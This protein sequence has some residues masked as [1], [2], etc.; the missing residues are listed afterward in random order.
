MP[1]EETA[2]RAAWT[3]IDWGR[4]GENEYTRRLSR[5]LLK[6]TRYANEQY[7]DWPDRENCGH[8]FGGSYWYGI[9]SAYTAAVFAAVGTMPEYDEAVTGMPQQEVRSK[10]IRAIRYLSFTHDTGPEECVRVEGPN[11]HCSRKKW[12]GRG[13]PFFRASQTGTVVHAMAC[14]AWLLH[15]ELDEETKRLMESVLEYY[16]DRYSAMKPGTGVYFD[17]QCEENGWT[18][19]GIGAAA[20]LLPNHP[21]GGEWRQAA[22]RWA[23]N[24]VTTPGDNVKRTGGVSTVT[25]HPDYTTE[26]HAFVH[27]SY[28][29]AGISLRGLYALLE[30]MAGS[31]VPEQ[32]TVGNV[33]MYERTI[34]LWSYT[35]GIPVPIQGQDWWYNLHHASMMCHAFIHVLHGNPDA[36]AL[37][38]SAL[39]FVEKLQIS[40]TR[41]CLLE[42][43]G[44]ACI[45]TEGHQTAKEMEFGCAHSVLI[46]Y[47][48][49]RFGGAGTE[50]SGERDLS[51]AVN[52]VHY[53]PYGSS[54][55]HRTDV[56]FTAFS[57]RNHVMAITLPRNGVWSV[58]PA[59]SS[60][61][62]EVEFDGEQ[63]DV[64][65]NETTPVECDEQHL[66][67]FSDGFGAV[68]ELQRGKGGKLLQRIGF[69]SLPDGRSFYA[70]RIRIQRPCTIKR[71]S[72]GLIGIRN[73]RYSALPGYA[74]G[75]KTVTV[76]GSTKQFEGYYGQDPDIVE[77][78][79]PVPYI[80]VN[81]EIG[82]VVI[83]SDNVTYWNRHQYAKWKG[84][85]DVLTLNARSGLLFGG[86]AELP[87][88]AVLALPNASVELTRESANATR[89]LSARMDDCIVAETEGYLILVNFGG[90]RTEYQV[91]AVRAGRT[92]QL[93]DGT[94]HVNGGQ[95][96][97]TGTVEASYAGYAASR[98]RLELP[99][100]LPDLFHLTVTV[101]GARVYVT[102]EARSV[103]NCTLT[104]TDTG[105]S[106]LRREVSIEGLCT[107]VFT[108]DR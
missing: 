46:A 9:E 50:P 49:H 71:L 66:H 8:F 77:S 28:M 21:R 72:T 83:G 94:Q 96:V 7:A 4:A 20:A 64:A 40:N 52:G 39:E 13:D 75:S 27:P 23:R 100:S 102:N 65:Y 1:N 61:I 82:Y 108:F 2:S 19:S 36:A 5:V 91:T 106:G 99:E 57:W 81:G 73:E 103:S 62:G 18:S 29:M 93:F 17:T 85:E 35:D 92:V 34:K 76:P 24:S 74:D 15:D 12:G 26:N 88:F 104:V 30:M 38:R 25:F 98:F 42:Q 87:V 44:E 79:G 69:V 43:N 37:E 32:L 59:Y 80:N 10:A 41:G 16:A 3:P 68:A 48:L 56:S 45:V 63:P 105:S 97:R 6:W 101:S 60:Y 14:A 89:L 55:V 31:P 84:V 95:I 51:E 54:I 67:R 53:Y 70:E 78:F 22:L 107:S 33:P 86:P 90:R 11:P 47:L 58:T